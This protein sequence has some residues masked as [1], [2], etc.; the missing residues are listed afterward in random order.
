MRALAKIH[1]R[2][3]ALAKIGGCACG[4]FLLSCGIY[5]FSCGSSCWDC[6]GP[7]WNPCG[8]FPFHTHFLR[9]GP[10]AWSLLHPTQDDL[11]VRVCNDQP[12]SLCWAAPEHVCVLLGNRQDVFRD[13]RVRLGVAVLVGAGRCDDVHQRGYSAEATNLGSLWIFQW[14]MSGMAHQFEVAILAVVRLCTA[15]TQIA[16]RDDDAHQQ[17]A[18]SGEYPNAEPGQK[19]DLSRSPT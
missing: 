4:M 9:G 17:D 3:R 18:E 12:D 1:V 10:K 15:C 16:G 14:P 2:M 13:A 7:C 8:A 6:W 19:S 5:G 11:G